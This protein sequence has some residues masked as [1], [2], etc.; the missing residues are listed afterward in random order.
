MPLRRSGGT[1]TAVTVDGLRDLWSAAL[2]AAG[3]ALR[4]AGPYLPP[5]ELHA[6][7]RSLVAERDS[8]ARLL[9]ALAHDQPGSS[10]YLHLRLPRW[11]AQ[12][13]LGLPSEVEACVFNLDGVLIGSA[14]LHAAAWR[15]TFDEL[16]SNRVERTGAR[17]PPF[18]PRTDY[19]AY[20]HGRPR[21][22][23]VRAFLASRGIRLPEGDPDD[24]PGTET[25]HGVA[26]RK[27]QALL[28]LID[29]RGVAAF[30]G[31]R[32]YLE[33][34]RDAGLRRGVISASANTDAMLARAGLTGLIDAKV[35]GAAIV[36]EQL[37][38]RPAADILLAAC[39]RL[40]VSPEHAAVFETSPAGV[41]SGRAGGFGLVVGIDRAGLAG[42]LRADGADMVVSGLAEL[43][44]RS[45]A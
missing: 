11:Q 4:S 22:E 32:R 25:V 17:V 3:S 9:A 44:D 12:R 5:E 21:L 10:R 6:R 34:V 26:N 2:E 40:G 20:M 33:L 41:A 8:T 24:A 29:E 42:A 38:P 1:L 15:Q 35:D 43:L 39:R 27:S 36:A 18:N 37:R 31:S 23:G 30:E 14:S 45:A 28:R 13:L 19:P 16:I 7:S